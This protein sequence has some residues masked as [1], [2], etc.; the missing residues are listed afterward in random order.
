M[1]DIHRVA[2][3][4]RTARGF[5]SSPLYSALLPVVAADDALLKLAA[6]TRRG[7]QPTFALF[8]AVHLLLLRG[9]PDPLAEYYPSVVADAA[10]PVDA[11]T[12]AAFRSFCAAHSAQI[13]STISTRL[14]QT[15]HVQRALVIRLGLA[16]LR[17][18]TRGP[19]CVIEIGCSAGLNL[20]ADRY[21]YTVAGATFGDHASPVHIRADASPAELLPDLSRLPI[22]ADTAGIDLA[23]PDLTDSDDR[24]WLRALVWPENSHQAAQLQAAMDLVAADPPKVL[25]GDA[26]SLAPDL[27]A[28]LP[29]GLPRLVVHTA[30]RIHVPVDEAEAFDAA[31]TTFAADGPML[32]LA[33]EDDHRVA[34]SGRPGI[35]LVATDAVGRRPIAVADGHLAWLE[36]LAELR[37]VRLTVS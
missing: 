27:A 35:G 19:V 31:V 13:S 10:R 7:Q 36:P 1:Q 34:P 29:A 37:D 14:V 25:R 20:R 4:F 26:I 28:T 9:T 17:R 22:I 23:P 24:D 32:H 33:L 30:T 2:Q 12:A 6:H 3:A 16:L 8:G 5:D 15:N 18:A 11:A 21:T